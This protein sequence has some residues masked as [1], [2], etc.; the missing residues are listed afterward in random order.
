M[1]LE[2]ER[3]QGLSMHEVVGG[4]RLSALVDAVQTVAPPQLLLFDSS[5]PRA[6]EHLLAQVPARH[7]SLEDRPCAAQTLARLRKNLATLPSRDFMQRAVEM[8]TTCVAVGVGGSRR[9][10]AS[11]D[12]ALTDVT[13]QPSS[14]RTLKTLDP[15]HLEDCSILEDCKQRSELRPRSQVLKRTSGR[16]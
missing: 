16:L 13:C 10:L 6:R 4:A 3:R 9:N 12:H 14:C 15:S 5:H 2:C 1:R 7:S 8:V 11:L